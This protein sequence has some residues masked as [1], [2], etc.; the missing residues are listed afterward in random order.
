MAALATAGATLAAPVLSL[1]A[2][3]SSFLSGAASMPAVRAPAARVSMVAEAPSGFTP[4][5]EARHPLPHLRRQHRR[6]AEEGPG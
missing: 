4:H 6:P 2:T 3:R 5:P 1:N